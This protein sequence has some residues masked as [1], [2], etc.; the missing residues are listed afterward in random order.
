MQ[1]SDVEI[2]RLVKKGNVSTSEDDSDDEGEYDE[3]EVSF[4]YIGHLFLAHGF[5]L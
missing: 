1:D 2:P 4:Q 5:Q 3:D